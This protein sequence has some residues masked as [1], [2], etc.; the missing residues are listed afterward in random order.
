MK[1]RL[2]KK[3][4]VRKDSTPDKMNYRSMSLEIRE[5]KPATLNEDN[6][7]VEVIGATEEPVEVFDYERYEIVKEIL[8][9]D[10]AEMPSNRQMPVLDS[11]S[12]YSTASVL[13]SFR[14]MK[15]EKGQLIGRVHFSSAQEAE[16]VWTKVREGHLTD[17]SVGYRVIKAQW[18][19]EGESTKINGRS[20]V[21]PVKVATRWRPKELS[22]VPI[23]ADEL[24]KTRSDFKEDAEKLKKTEVHKMPEGLRKKLI[25]LGMRV[26]ATDDEAWA[27]FESRGFSLEEPKKAEPKKIE[28]EPAVVKVDEKEIRAEAQRVERERIAEIDG[29]ARTFGIPDEERQNMISKGLSVEDAR[30]SVLDFVAKNGQQAIGVG[31]VYVEREARDKFR[32]A[33]T[34]SL[35]LRCQGTIIKAPEKV[36]P[37]AEELRGMTL[38]ELARESL[39]IAGVR[40]PSNSLELVGRALTTGDLPYVL[41]ATANKA[42]LAGYN[43]APETWRT[44]CGIG[45]ASD[46]KT[47]TLHRVSEADGLEEVP[48]EGDYQYGKRSEK[49]ESYA[50]ATYGKIFA[51]TRQ[52]IINDDLGALTDTPAK[53]GRAAARKVGDVAYAVLTANAAMGDGV[54]LFASG[55]SNYVASGSGAAPGMATIAAGIKAMGLQKDLN[56]ESYLNIRPEFFLGTKALEGAAEVFFNSMQYADIDTIATDSAMAATRMNPYAGSYFNRVYDARLDGSVATGW[57]LAGP[58]GMT[59][60]VFFLNGVQAPYVEQK[61]GWTVDGTEYKVRIDVAAKAVDW[62]ALYYNY[63]A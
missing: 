47:H 41:G 57:F 52:S 28:P 11:H 49:K 25:A 48:E 26:D 1:K 36:A 31:G 55:H 45:S 4:Q 33:A 35:L 53:H 2:Q 54:A 10:G 51:I 20:F 63:G 24:A 59:V 16:P 8:L 15:I 19:P 34:D 12:R 17:F 5:G 9:M 18:V 23:G 62:V 42:L 7:S 27:F 37:G 22:A 14:G 46:F 43:L 44:W 21:G 56:S 29:M 61:N 60:D 13:G 40:I 6:R 32:D 3:L 50:L 58:K 30:K 39:R 38:R